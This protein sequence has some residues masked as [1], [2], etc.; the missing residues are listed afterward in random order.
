M[1]LAHLHHPTR[2]LRNHNIQPT[3][4]INKSILSNLILILN[5]PMIIPMTILKLLMKNTNRSRNIKHSRR[6]KRLSRINSKHIRP[7]K[8]NKRRNKKLHRKMSIK[9]IKNTN[10]IRSTNRNMLK[11]KII[12]KVILIILTNVKLVIR[13]WLI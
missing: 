3:R 1:I 2:C 12:R 13:E 8:K 9:S 7:I 11:I 10:N 6:N 5:I 4:H